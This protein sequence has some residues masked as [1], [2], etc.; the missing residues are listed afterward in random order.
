MIDQLLTKLQH[1]DP[2]FWAILGGYFAPYI[3]EL[4]KRLTEVGER[5]NYFIA[6]VLLPLAIAA[7]TGLASPQLLSN[8]HPLLQVVIPALVAAVVGQLKYGLS[9]NPH[10]KQKAEL[11]SLK[12][13]PEPMIFSDPTPESPATVTDY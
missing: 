9:L 5:A 6:L 7:L 11:A 10:L 3:Q 13:T 8:V 12:A 4:L 1:I 2:L